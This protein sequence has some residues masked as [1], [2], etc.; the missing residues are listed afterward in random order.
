[1]VLVEVKEEKVEYIKKTEIRR[2]DMPYCDG[3]ATNIVKCHRCKGDF[4]NKH[5]YTVEGIYRT[6]YNDKWMGGLAN[7]FFCPKC[8]P[9]A[10][11]ELLDRD[12][13]RKREKGE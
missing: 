11:D 9:L 3:D 12:C 7:V 10:I 6:D 4:C 8:L 2:C 13:L 1:M 5:L